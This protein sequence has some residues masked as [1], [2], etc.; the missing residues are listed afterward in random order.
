M[1]PLREEAE[2]ILQ[3]EGWTKAA[4]GKMRKLDSFM[5]ESQRLNGIS[6][7]TLNSCLGQI[8]RLTLRW[9][10]ILA[11]VMRK[12]LTSIKFSNG[13]VIPPNSF[14]VAAATGTHLDEDNYENPEIF[15]PWRFSNMREAEGEAL[16]HQ[17]VS[18]SLD[19]V[20][21]GH[22]KHAW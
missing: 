18:T 17:F 12:T 8:Q 14:I 2:A 11:S 10:S 20:P 3:V 21:F 15:N 19:Y 22:G 4:M 5:R 9:F 7:S 13:A 16:K 6:G 1:G